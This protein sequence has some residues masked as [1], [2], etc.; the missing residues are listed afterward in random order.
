MA[1]PIGANICTNT[2]WD[3]APKIG[4]WRA[5]AHMHAR[6]AL[7][8]VRTPSHVQHRRSDV[9]LNWAQNLY[10]YSLVLCVKD[11]GRRAARVQRVIGAVQ[12]SRASVKRE[13]EH[14]TRDN[15]VVVGRRSLRESE[16]CERAAQRVAEKGEYLRQVLERVIRHSRIFVQPPTDTGYRNTHMCNVKLPTRHK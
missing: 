8:N 3:Y 11:R 13:N 6:A 15:S 7:A 9:W 2:Q 16:A 5:R 14:E 4:G 10:K 12:P 1:G